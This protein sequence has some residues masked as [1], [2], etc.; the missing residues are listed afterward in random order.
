M[1][2]FKAV[3]FLSQVLDSPELDAVRDAVQNLQDIGE[4]KTVLVYS[5]HYVTPFQMQSLNG[6]F[7]FTGVLDKTETLTPLG[8][9]VACMS[10]DPR[11]GKVLVLGSL[12]RCVLPMLSVA[13]SL[14]RDP[15]HNSLQNR[16]EVNKV[17][18]WSTPLSNIC[19]S[20]QLKKKK[21][22]LSK[23][24]Q[25]LQAKET[26]SGRSCSDYLV[27]IR[28]VLGWR[29]VQQEGDREGRDEYLDKHTLS[30]FSL[31]FINGLFKPLH[32]TKLQCALDITL[33]FP[34]LFKL[35]LG[36]ISQ[37]STNLYEAQLV[38]HASKCQHN[39][40]LCNEHSNQEELLKAVLLAGL[41]PNLIQVDG[42]FCAALI[43]QHLHV[44]VGIGV[45]TTR[46][47][48]LSPR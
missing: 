6:S 41:F 8:E 40:S 36:L 19:I 28:A 10:C 14:T 1:F 42:K 29:R 32:F 35:Y 4:T 48:F 34:F 30:K 20:K 16:K 15:F 23:N 45:K 5:V 3:D 46:C 25:C 26:L 2:C 17:K 38:P 21:S 22:K 47:A 13:A 9:H 11:L 7:S 31:R 18:R 37:F 43:L 39:T 44:K 24:H 12:F 27:F 33:N